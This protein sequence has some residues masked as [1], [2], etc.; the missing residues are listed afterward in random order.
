MQKGMRSIWPA[1]V[2]NANGGRAFVCA[3][4]ASSFAVLRADTNESLLCTERTF[5]R[6][7]YHVHEGRISLRET[8]ERNRLVL[9]VAVSARWFTWPRK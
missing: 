2:V 3:S 9:R 8:S 5:K 6:V 7:D 4:K 1:F